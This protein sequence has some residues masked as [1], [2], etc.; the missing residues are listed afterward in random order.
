MQKV[1]VVCG[2]DSEERAISLRSGQS[3]AEAL[4]SKG[5]EVLVLD[6]TCRDEELKQSDVVFPVLHGIGGEDGQFQARLETLGINFVGSD[7]V[8]SRLCMDKAAYR[9][10]MIAA[11]LT[12]PE[13]ETVNKDGYFAS[14][15]SQLPHVL[16]PIQGGSTIDTFVI[17]NLKQR[18]IKDI[19][20]A[21]ERYEHMLLEELITGPEIT[22]GVLDELAL[23]VIEIIPPQ[24]E[25][26]SCENKYNG[27][28]QELC[29]PIHISQAVQGKSQKLALQIHK[30]AGCRDFSRTDFMISLDEKLYLLETNT[31]PGMTD[32]SLY[33]KMAAVAGLD[34]PSL[35]DRLVRLACKRA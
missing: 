9:E 21:F 10:A 14:K 8:S 28:T 25:E 12:M 24:G 2:G 4:S 31:I 35:V 16:K 30:A 18:K 32:Q 19:E 7:S 27:K 15:L 6:T 33:P 3:V 5:Y 26:F 20:E 34:F 11:G 22:V 13:G 29:P 23:P 17:R 1:I